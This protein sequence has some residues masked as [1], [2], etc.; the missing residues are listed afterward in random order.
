MIQRKQVEVFVTHDG[1]EFINYADAVDHEKR[2][3]VEAWA[4]V[5]LA[6]DNETIQEVIDTIMERKEQLLKALERGD[7]PC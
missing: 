2:L 4:D 5:Y 7:A 6:L 1:R 3:A